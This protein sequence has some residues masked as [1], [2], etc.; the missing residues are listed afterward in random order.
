[1]SIPGS[2]PPKVRATRLIC[3]RSPIS[4]SPA[5]G[6]CTFTATSRPSDQRPRCT[7]PM[8][9]A[10]AGSSSNSTS[11]ERQRV[12]SSEASTWWTVAAC[13]GGAES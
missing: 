2:M 8:E 7:C 4:A 5:P 10:A 6:Y 3:R 1:M 9:A 11:L 12:P 13:I